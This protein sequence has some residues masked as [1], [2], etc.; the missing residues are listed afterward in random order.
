MD[1]PE[2]KLT[3]MFCIRQSKDCGGRGKASEGAS[4][5]IPHE[6]AELRKYV[7]CKYS[8]SFKRTGSVEKTENRRQNCNGRIWRW[9]DLGCI[10]RRMDL[11][12]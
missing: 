11:K 6:S 2:K 1:F 8:D 9:A 10:Y 4:G 3:A 7:I 5:K 12:R